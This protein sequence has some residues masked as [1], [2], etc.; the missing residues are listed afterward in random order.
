[1]TRISRRRPC[2]LFSSTE[3]RHSRIGPPQIQYMVQGVLVVLFI[4]M[5][6]TNVCRHLAQKWATTYFQP[7]AKRRLLPWETTELS[8]IE[9]LILLD[10]LGAK[11]PQI[12]SSFL[13]TAWLF[14]AMASAERRLG[15][16]GAFAYGE[17]KSTGGSWTSFFYH[18]QNQMFNFGG[19]EDDHI[20]FLKLGVSVLHVV[21]NPFPRVWHTLKVCKTNLAQV[22]I[23]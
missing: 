7:H 5:A 2:S 21:A 11:D 22:R 17:E 16:S 9:H 10:L 1:M 13:D 14:D 3:K 23:S 8:T 6:C 4:P 18:R 19:V 15:E 20:P 12:R